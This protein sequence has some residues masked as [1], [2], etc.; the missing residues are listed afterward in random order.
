MEAESAEDLDEALEHQRTLDALAEAGLIEDAASDEGLVFPLPD[1]AVIREIV[2]RYDTRATGRKVPCAVCPQ[3]QRHYRGFRVALE[4]GDE[5]RMGINCGEKE[6]G[7][8]AW[9]RANADFNRR[10]QLATYQARVSPALELIGKIEPLVAEWHER[11]KRL[12]RWISGFRR[13]VPALFTEI[14]TAALRRGGRFEIERMKGREGVNAAGQQ[15]TY[16]QAEI[17]VLGRIP[18]PDMFLG[19]TPGYRLNG[20]IQSLREAIAIFDKQTD[21]A[22]LA[23]AFRALQRAR[24]HLMD[25]DRAHQGA[26]LNLDPAWIEP[27]CQWANRH[28]ALRAHYW[29]EGSSLCHSE[30]AGDGALAVMERSQLGRSNLDAILEV[31]DS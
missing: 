12:G 9:D 22:S 25:A 29:V 31:W 10:V 18:F 13:E 24:Q 14:G 7:K 4:S 27:L 17:T 3:H 5:A 30:V 11:A 15:I 28:D 1:G 6:F 2:A 19:E 8:D 21:A 26:L 20:A 23:R 16:K